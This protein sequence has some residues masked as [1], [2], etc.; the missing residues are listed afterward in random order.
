MIV[1][2][3]EDLRQSIL[4]EVPGS[5][6]TMHLSGNK[7]YRDLRELYWWPGL[8]REVTDFVAHYLTCQQVKAEHQVP[9]NR[10][11]V[12]EEYLPL[13]EFAYNNNFQSSIQMAPYEALYGRKCCTLLCWTELGERHVLSPE[14]V[15]EIKDKVRLIRDRLKVASDR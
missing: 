3:D 5:P 6:Y 9:S 1:S 13:A 14:L 7:M 11:S 2:N 12:R 10:W 8:K 15:S 4:R